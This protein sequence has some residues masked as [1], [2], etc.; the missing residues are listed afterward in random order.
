MPSPCYT[1][2][3]ETTFYFIRGGVSGRVSDK[4][5]ECSTPLE[6]RFQL[7]HLSMIPYRDVKNMPTFGTSIVDVCDVLGG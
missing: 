1:G 2:A 6:L 7:H 4:V 5:D 3:Y